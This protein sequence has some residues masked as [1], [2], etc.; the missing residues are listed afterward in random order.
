LIYSMK[1]APAA[2]TMAT[3]PWPTARTLAAPLKDEGAG[4]AELIGLVAA[5]VVAPGAVPVAATV[6]F[7]AT[8]NG[9]AAEETTA[10]VVEAGVETALEEA[11]LLALEV[12]ETWE[13][14]LSPAAEINEVAALAIEPVAAHAKVSM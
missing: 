5:G 8:G 4:L 14:V 12:V 2:A 11:T 7:P 6:E 9:V 10:A 13:S 1:K 3:K